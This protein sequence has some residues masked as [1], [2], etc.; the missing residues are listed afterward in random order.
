M[1]GF[2]LLAEVASSRNKAYGIVCTHF[3]AF[4]ESDCLSSLCDLRTLVQDLLHHWDEKLKQLLSL[5]WYQLK[6]HWYKYG[7]IRII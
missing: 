5:I 2:D 7:S 6:C 1:I 4:D 3:V